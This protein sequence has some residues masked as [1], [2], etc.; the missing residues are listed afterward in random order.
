MLDFYGAESIID[1]Q[2]EETEV[3]IEEIES[4]KN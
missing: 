2:I 3:E 1:E 4:N